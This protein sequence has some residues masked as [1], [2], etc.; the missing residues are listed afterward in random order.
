MQNKIYCVKAEDVELR[1]IVEDYNI[2]E[3]KMGNKYNTIL[4]VAV[5]SYGFCGNST[6]IV[7]YNDLVCFANKLKQMFDNLCGQI[8]MQDRDLGSAINVECDQT[9]HFVFDGQIVSNT[10]QKLIF[11]FVLDQTYLKKFIYK[12]YEDFGKY[13]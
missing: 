12:I 3:S 13:N 8:K 1:I 5:N 9:G 2:E 10:F 4:S 6:W 7:D 11:N